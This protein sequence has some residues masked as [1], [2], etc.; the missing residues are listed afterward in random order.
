MD[1]QS[2]EPTV[3]GQIPGA[4]VLASG[5]SHSAFRQSQFGVIECRWPPLSL[6]SFMVKIPLGT[7]NTQ[8]HLLSS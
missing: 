4:W 8:P 7:H 6:G 5:F 3:V 1:P 2:P